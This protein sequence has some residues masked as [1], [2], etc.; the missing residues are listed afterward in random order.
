MQ[1][2]ALTA[3]V[4]IVREQSKDDGL[5]FCAQTAAE[6]YLQQELRRLHAAVE[7]EE[8]TN[9]ERAADRRERFIRSAQR[10]D[11]IPAFPVAAHYDG[12]GNPVHDSHAGMS[13]RDYFAARAP[14]MTEQWFRD[15]RVDGIH[16][17]DAQ[18][19]YSYAHADA[20]LAERKKA[21]K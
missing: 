9:V 5:W 10:D 13:L 21:P 4:S 17:I 1:T 8:I 14:V 7:R 18:A 2:P 11:A 20:M 15:S 3:A 19:A 12:H 16:W 6:A